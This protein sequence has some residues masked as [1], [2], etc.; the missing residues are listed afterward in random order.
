MKPRLYLA[1]TLYSRDASA[2]QEALF[3]SAQTLQAARAEL[4]RYMQ[5]GG[6]GGAG[7]GE[8]VAGGG[9]P[10]D[11]AVAMEVAGDDDRA[12]GTCPSYE[13]PEPPPP[14]LVPNVRFDSASAYVVEVLSLFERLAAASPALRDELL[15]RGVL[16]E[17]LGSC[18]TNAP[19]K[20]QARASRLLCLLCHGSAEA[21]DRLNRA[22]SARLE[23]CVASHALLPH[24]RLL[25]AEV[26]LLCDLCRMHDALWP[27]R[28]GMLLRALSRAL[29]QLGS[30][31]LCRRLLLPCLRV[32][33][34]ILGPAP[35]AGTPAPLPPVDMAAWLRD[36]PGTHAAWCAAAARG[37][38]TQQLSR[39]EA[40]AHRIGRNWRARGAGEPAAAGPPT[41]WLCEL[42]LCPPSQPVRE[43]GC[44]LLLRLAAAGDGANGPALDLL[45]VL[46][47][48]Y[49]PRAVAAGGAVSAEFFDALRA[50]LA[51]EPR[52]LFLVV[53][54]AL[55]RLCSLIGGE[56]ARVQEQERADA[57]APVDLSQGRVLRALAELLASLVAAPAIRARLRREGQLPTLLSALLAARGLVAQ[58]TCHTEAAAATLERL[59]AAMH[60]ESDGERA[61]FM[62]ACVAA[63]REHAGAAAADAASF[64]AR[65]GGGS[66]SAVADPAAADGGVAA[67][68]RALTFLLG[69]L[70]GLVCPERAEPD[71]ALQ[72]NKAPTQEEFIRGAMAK[73]P[74]TSRAIGPLMRDVKNRICRDLDMLGLIEDDN[75]MELLV[76]GSIIK[77]D[78]PVAAVYEQ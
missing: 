51:P 35:P 56:A 52:R 29:E 70:C 18:L 66:E 19:R 36:P 76:A 32:L 28:L 63:M 62:A 2:A 53:R 49:L 17:L 3:K 64:A 15:A 42:L 57:G 74:Y 6:S 71:Y 25:E 75:G 13:P 39:G 7:S 33:I 5:S 8:G 47:R 45:D 24:D 4:L 34:E 1:A 9:E 65:A 54:G 27:D 58:R 44:A 30:A 55:G 69:Q 22:L 67:D 73:N 60:E 50:L 78:L 38:V 23:L 21:T 26:G 31:L 59:L 11:G 14:P 16:D 48:A 43:A 46:E 40:A 77:L 12:G 41:N 37:V 72:L 10:G 20:M 61:A 68:A